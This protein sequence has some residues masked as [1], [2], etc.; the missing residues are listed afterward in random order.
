MEAVG[1]LTG[2]I[3]HDFNNILTV[4]TGNLDMAQRGLNGQQPKLERMID[5]AIRGAERAASLTG[6]LLAFARRQALEP[7]LI[8]VNRLVGGMSELV[9]R[10]LGEP[11]GIE[12][13]LSACVWNIFCDPNQLESAM[14]NLVLNARDAMPDGGR[15]TIE[16]QN[17]E[18]DETYA[19]SQD[20][21]VPGQYVMISISD[22]GTGMPPEVVAQVFEPFFTTKRTGEGS[23][24]GLSMVYGFIKQ[25]GGHIKISSEVS[26]GTVVKLYL[27]RHF[28][29]GQPAWAPADRTEL[30]KG[31]GHHTVLVVEDDPDVRDYSVHVLTELG[32]QV[33]KAADG[34]SALALLQNGY[35][36]DLLFTDVVLP[37]MN[38]REL[39]RRAGKILPG[40]KVIFTTGYTRSAII[41]AGR[42]DS[43][44][45]LVA[46]PFTPETLARRVRAA[47]AESG[48]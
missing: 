1:Q 26:H 40:L 16:T 21:V 46:K 3:A 19:A 2:G 6:R 22:T 27:P 34:P 13:V 29:T 5:M 31:S 44:V 14:L 23:G 15:L 17:A 20:E 36:V 25:S 39:A 32:Y 11:I 8:D 48:S 10:T 24:L 37:G 47:L 28:G 45:I 43:D 42:L 18:L 33:I 38:G 12:T 4:I 35:L 30:P 41:H 9:R 7:A